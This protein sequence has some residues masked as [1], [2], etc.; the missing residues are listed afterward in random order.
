MQVVMLIKVSCNNNLIFI[1]P[2]PFSCFNTYT[3]TLFRCYFTFSEALITVI[4]Y[5]TAKL[6]VMKFGCYHVLIGSLD[7]T[8]NSGHI[9]LFIG[10]LLILGVLQSL[11]QIFI[12][13][14]FVDGFVRV[15]SILNNLF[16]SALY[17]PKSCGSNSSFTSFFCESISS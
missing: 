4:S 13:V 2:H 17:G 6:S 3:V 1:S 11:I 16:Q 10:F 8:V 5:I 12:N 15:F 9:K 7:G 14:F